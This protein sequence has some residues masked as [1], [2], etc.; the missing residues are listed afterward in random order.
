MLIVAIHA[1]SLIFNKMPKSVAKQDHQQ[2]QAA[3]CPT[4][5]KYNI[6]MSFNTGFYDQGPR[7]GKR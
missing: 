4:G 2:T 1:K 7:C 3:Y 5:K 6:D